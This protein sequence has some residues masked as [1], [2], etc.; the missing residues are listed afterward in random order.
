M[1]MYCIKIIVIMI[2][3]WNVSSFVGNLHVHKRNR[4]QIFDGGLSTIFTDFPLTTAAI[5]LTGSFL[6]LKFSIYAKMQL[7]TVEMIG[8]IPENQKIVE[9]WANDG[10]NVFY[11]PKG[12][13]IEYVSAHN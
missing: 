8:N 13:K 1:M 4:Q 10:K 7:E 2:S 3:M 9:L 12:V 5:A 6:L 11:L